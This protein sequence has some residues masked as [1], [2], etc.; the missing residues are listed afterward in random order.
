M[1]LLATDA[2]AP[3]AP[4]QYSVAASA[5]EENT[6]NKLKNTKIPNINF[7]L[8]LTNFHIPNMTT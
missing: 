1:E 6:K 3:S 8:L 7:N 4:T 2:L 5:L